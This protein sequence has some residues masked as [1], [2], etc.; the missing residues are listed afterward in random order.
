[1]SEGFDSGISLE[2]L[3][4]QGE[5]YRLGDVDS[6]FYAIYGM[7]GLKESPVDE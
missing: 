3:L 1:M 4:L 6:C 2:I 5:L 7:L